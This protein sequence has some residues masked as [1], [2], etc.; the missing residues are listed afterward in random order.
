MTMD[1]AKQWVVLTAVGVL[2]VMAGGWF[3]LVSPKRSEASDIRALTASQQTTNAGLQSQLVRLKQQAKV[4]PA[5]QA[6]LAAVAAKIPDNPALPGLV[7]ALTKAA[8]ASGV[9]LLSMAPGTPTDVAPPAAAQPVTPSASGTTAA[10]PQTPKVPSAT[11]V[12]ASTAG[13]LQLI[14]MNVQVVGGYFQIEQFLDALESLSRAFKTT[15]LTIAPGDNPVKPKVV[16][17]TAPVNDGRTLQAT[18][19][20]NV[21][22]A[23]GRG[24]A[25]A[26][27]VPVK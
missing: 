19:L 11:A 13:T 1:K 3:L 14:G 10:S 4:L 6:K 15:G 18:I 27:V 5:Q 25:T 20:G 24:A 16:G 7:R 9:E 12:P 17:A 21:Y 8:D 22:M 23:S 26:P 2:A